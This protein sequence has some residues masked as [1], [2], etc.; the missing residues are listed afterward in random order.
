MNKRDQSNF[1]LDFQRSA[2]PYMEE[3]N[4][5]ILKQVEKIGHGAAILDVGAG[6][7]ALGEVLC[8]RG[9]DVCIIESNEIA[10][11]EASLRVNQVICADLHDL[12]QINKQLNKKKFKYIIFSDI[13]EHV[14]DPLRVLRDYL[15]LLTDDG[16]LLI[17]LPNALN[18][19]NRLYFMLGMFNYEMTGTMDRTHIR[20]FTFR[21]AKKMLEANH[22][23]VEK[24]D[25][26]PFI[27]RAFL[28]LIKAV[29]HKKNTQSVGQ[30]SI[31]GI[32][33]SPLYK[34]YIK[35]IYPIEYWITRVMPSL[36]AFR[37]I[38]IAHSKVK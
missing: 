37:I 16:K 20:F 14:Y 27:V 38:L 17:S 36:L 21:T 5:G 12:D 31:K 15:P 30:E 13:L 2:Y 26:T 29:L 4:E 10:A 34:F 24:I 8:K 22:C 1:I 9:Y 6:R 11:K 33:D 23:V 19:L 7:G 18:W 28:P 25:S 3:V 35:Y 32:V